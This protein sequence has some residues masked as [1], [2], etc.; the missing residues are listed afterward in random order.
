MFQYILKRILFFI[1]TLIIIS[2]LAFVIS[3]NAPGDP[4]E[5]I[6]SST[7]GANEQSASSSNHNEL[8]KLWKHKLGLDLP[9]FYFSIHSAALP[10]SLY[11]IVDKEERKKAERKILSESGFIKFIPSISF[12]LHNQYHR[13]LLGDGETSQGI[14]RG[15]FGIS[16]ITQQKISSLLAE[17]LPWSLFFSLCSIFIAYIIS[18]PLGVF[19]A[20]KKGTR[21]EKLVSIFVFMLPAIPSFWLATMLMMTFSNPD[22]INVL[23]S[24]GVKPVEGFADGISWFEKIKI[25]I[26]Y[27]IMPIIC[28]TYGSIA[29]LSRTMRVGMLETLSMDFIRTARAKGLSEK[30][31]IWKH[32]FRNSLLPIITVF[33]NVFPAAIGG[34]VILETVFTIPGMGFS[35]YQAIGN[36][37]YP[38]IVAVFTLT[39][40]LTLIG[41]LVSDI[42]YAMV[43]PRIKFS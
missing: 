25:T 31:V 32:A 21:M 11:Q 43:D 12:H 42:L 17:K 6:V 40:L 5:R 15:D 13:W 26:P 28:F 8:L 4:V 24:S 18:I 30:K 10:D 39:G 3:V 41:Y 38:V 14:L 1:P 20:S 19:A 35:I 36:H 37:D 7:Q 33:A 2:L 27:L 9:I 16:I 22:V 29:F 34:S 23:P